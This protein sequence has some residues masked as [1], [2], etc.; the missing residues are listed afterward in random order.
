NY[1]SKGILQRIKEN[2]NRIR[3]N[4][5]E[6]IAVRKEKSFSEELDLALDFIGDTNF[7]IEID[8]DA[9]E[10]LPSSAMTFSGFSAEKTRRFLHVFASDPKACYLHICE[11]APE[12]SDEKNPN[13]IG[14]LI[15]YLITDFMK[16]KIGV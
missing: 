2:P 5:Y 9:I 8:L 16:A 6:Q 4:T 3:Y 11:G 12:L 13:L 15:A 10:N 7:G 14:K 1:T